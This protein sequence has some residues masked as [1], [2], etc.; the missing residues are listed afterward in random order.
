[1]Q[2]ER[3]ASLCSDSSVGSSSSTV[4][5]SSETQMQNGETLPNGDDAKAKKAVDTQAMGGTS[6]TP[7]TTVSPSSFNYSFETYVK[8]NYPSTQVSPSKQDDTPVLSTGQSGTEPLGK[9]PRFVSCM[10]F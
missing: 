9:R 5:A 2:R 4:S 1:M 8:S 6:T 10:Y 7:N 3:T